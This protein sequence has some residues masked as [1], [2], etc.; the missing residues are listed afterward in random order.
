MLSKELSIQRKRKKE[1]VRHVDAGL[2]LARTEALGL[3][4]VAWTT[5]SKLLVQIDRPR[6]TLSRYTNIL[7]SSSSGKFLKPKR[8]IVFNVTLEKSSMI[9]VKA[10]WMRIRCVDFF[11]VSQKKMHI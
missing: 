4:V 1:R 8:S 5:V 7:Q 6:A 9:F 3:M 2:K 11:F 10:K